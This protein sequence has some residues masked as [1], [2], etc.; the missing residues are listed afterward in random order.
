M[1]TVRDLDVTCD[2]YRRVLGMQEITFGG[3]RRALAFGNQ[4]INLHL[5]GH[6]FEPK[7]ERAT[8][9]SADLCFVLEGS[10]DDAVTRL[11]VEKVPVLLGPADRIG[12]LGKMRSVYLRDPDGN[13]LELSSYDIESFS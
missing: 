4:K 10:L 12:A 1:L 13:L 5:A 3:G 6:E 9:G 7:A 2:F 8:A 11:G